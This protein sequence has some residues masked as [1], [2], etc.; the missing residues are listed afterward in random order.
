MSQ[1]VPTVS[2]VMPTRNQAPFIAAALD[3]VAAQARDLGAGALELVVADGGSGDGTQGLLAD[4]A[5][6]HP[7]SLRWSSAPDAGPAQAVNAAV[8]QARGALVGWLNSDDLYTP[9]AVARALAH[10]AQNPTH[11]M[12]YGEGEHV[13]ASGAVLGRYPTRGPDAPLDTWAQGCPVCQPTAFFRRD[14]FLA[15]GG[16]D[17]SLRTAFDFEFWLRLHKAH[18][19]RVGI[20]RQVQAQSRLHAGSITL[21][22]REQVALEGMAVLH[23]HLG[24]APPHW[25]L[26]HAAERCA[27]HPFDDGPPRDLRAELM[28]LADTARPW[29]DADGDRLLRERLAADR[30]L[31]LAT[32]QLLAP[33]H[34][35]GWAPPV[36]A[37]RVRQP[38]RPAPALR[39]R[40]RH[41]NPAGVPLRLTALDAQGRVHALEVPRNGP[42]EWRLPLADQRPHAR[43]VLRISADPAFVPA[44]VE[45]GSTDERALAW[46]V[47]SLELTAAG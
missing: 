5:A 42:F 35:D 1:P 11:V 44:Q 23:R 17:E 13:D 3:S 7:G 43:L 9:G 31:Q 24:V 29:L 10:L 41:A 45:P 20:V 33:V 2:I 6:A 27:T 22:Q 34:P 36:L 19:G 40:G 37:L 16:L 14:A 8:A 39:L 32:P 46:R 30:A 38:A 28:Q 12:V 26:T 47:E 25:L 15:L 18:P 4:R 21:R